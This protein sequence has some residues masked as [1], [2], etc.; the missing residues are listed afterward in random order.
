MTGQQ[1]GPLQG[2]PLWDDASVSVALEA[3]EEP[4]DLLAQAA[5]LGQPALEEHEPRAAERADEHAHRD[6]H[7]QQLEVPAS[8]TS[9][10]AVFCTCRRRRRG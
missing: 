5:V 8:L 3:L 6:P 10:T 2:R 9:I 1:S 7:G 4:H